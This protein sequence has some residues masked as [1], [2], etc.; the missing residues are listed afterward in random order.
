MLE[1]ASST[2]LVTLAAIVVAYQAYVL[3]AVPWIEPPLAVRPHAAGDGSPESIGR[4]SRSRKYQRLLAAYFPPDHWSQTRPPKVIENETGSV[5]FVLDDYERHDDGRVD[6]S[7]FALLIFPTPRQQ[8][9]RRRRATRSCSKRRKARSCSSTRTFGRSAARSARF[10]AASSPA[11]SRSAATCASRAGGRPRRSKRP[12]CEMNSKLLFTHER[13]PLPVGAERRRREGARDSAAGGGDGEVDGSGLKIASV[14][15]L[16]I[17]RDVRLRVFLN[18]NSL[19]PGDKP[20]QAAK[21]APAASPLGRHSSKPPVEVTCTGPFHF[22][23]IKYVASFDENVEVW[24]VNPEGPSRPAA[25]ATSSTS[26]LRGSRMPDAA[27]ERAS[28]DTAE[29][30]AGGRPLARTGPDRGRGLSGRDRVAVAERGGPRRP[31]AADAPTA[32]RWRSTAG[33]T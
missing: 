5:M 21:S 9:R 23:F 28:L 7:Q 4:R 30:A 26:V 8:T 18:A 1:R 3:A 14:D 12:T 11:R 27:A 19:L 25:A 22:D 24:Q 32:R 20:T 10:N 17:R 16:E 31:G 2:A 15:S 33:R 13:G 6:L 29:P